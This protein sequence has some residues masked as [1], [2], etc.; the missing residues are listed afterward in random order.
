MEKPTLHLLIGLPGSGKTT[1]AKIL[2]ELTDSVRVSSDDYRLLLFPKPKFTQKEHD[3]LYA[4]I[5]H[6]VEHL[7][8]AGHSV[9]YDANLNRRVHREEKYALARKYEAN[10]KLWWVQTEQELSKQRRV[11]ESKHHHLVPRDETPGEMHDR[12]SD[13][14]EAPVEDELYVVV[15][16]RNITEEIINKS[17]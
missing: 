7:L 6:N 4:M 3:N 11:E 9:V 1:L 2:Q 17:L 14:F 13:L 12:I 8:Q 15:D 5:D 10:V 16:G